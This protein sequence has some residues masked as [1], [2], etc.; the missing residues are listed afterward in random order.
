MQRY[1]LV[2]TT[3]ASPSEQVYI[4]AEPGLV[5]AQG[6]REG[7]FIFKFGE[8]HSFIL[9]IIEAQPSTHY[10]EA[11]RLFFTLGRPGFVGK[12]RLQQRRDYPNNEL[13]SIICGLDDL[14]R[15]W[16]MIGKGADVLLHG[17]SILAAQMPRQYLDGVGIKRAIGSRIELRARDHKWP[18]IEISVSLDTKTFP[19]FGSEATARVHVVRVRVHGAPAEF[20]AESVHHN[21]KMI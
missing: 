12:V 8:A 15:P 20:K 7:A 2:L 14:L 6:A 3:P 18:D 21:G 10:D 9:D 1:H 17:S 11:H 13:I 5:R 16:C 4:V 19:A